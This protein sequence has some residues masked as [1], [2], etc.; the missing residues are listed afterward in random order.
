MRETT[1]SKMSGVVHIPDFIHAKIGAICKISF[2]VE[3]IF[4][5]WRFFPAEGSS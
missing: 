4:Q 1:L 2:A 5:K 3:G